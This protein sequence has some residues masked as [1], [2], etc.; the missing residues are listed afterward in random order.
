M[1]NLLVSGNGEWWEAPSLSLDVNRFKEFSGTEADSVD[2]ARPETLRLLEE[3]PTLLMYE[4]GAD[5]PHKRL[6]R[7]GRLRNI[8]RRGRDLRF[9]FEPDSERAYLDRTVVLSFADQLGLEQFERHRT[10]WA[11]KDGN[12]PADLLDTATA[13]RQ[14]RTIGVVAAEYVE[15]KRE[16][17]HREIRELEAELEQ[18]PASLEK[19]LFLLPARILEHPTPELY[20]I[21]GI[22][23]STPE[24]RSA[25]EAVFARDAEQQDLPQDWAFSLGWFLDLYGSPTEAV[26]LNSAVDACAAK[27]IGLG[28]EGVGAA[29]S[30][31]EVAY[32][33]WRSSRS[34]L[35]V[36][37]LRREIAMLIDRLVRR[38]TSDGFWAEDRDGTPV[39]TVRATALATVAL[40]RLGDDRYHE[41]IKQAVLWLIAQV[42]P[43]TGGLPR[44]SGETEADVIATTLTME[45]IRRSDV[46]EQ[47]PHVLT[48]GDA[49][50]VA[51]QTV[52]GGWQAEPWAEN[53]VASMVLEYLARQS[54][55]LPQVD[56][57]LLMARDF[58]RKAEELRLEGGA[59]NRRL[60]AI[61]TVHAVEMFLYG[62]F[63]RR[64]D[65]AL[66]A[67]RE[68]GRET[69][70]PREALR[71]LQDALQR[72]GELTVPQRLPHRDNLSALIGKRDGIIHQAQEISEAELGDGMGHARRFIVRYAK[73]LLN[74]NLLQ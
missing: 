66:S 3:V 4:V 51:G 69:L 50:L 42:L 73:S 18:F 2:I 29:R 22:E 58:F 16:G 26:R 8:A 59:N 23:P 43:G 68:N 27:M 11:I 55:M 54:E 37:R 5:G 9:T 70:G 15:A 34:S 39:A 49:W 28:A 17:T 33:L 61:A 63:E 45:A 53:F 38:Q 65:L 60:A 57:F 36:G 52:L 72:I 40:Q 1:F 31:E 32:A 19:A 71:A 20:P 41:P 62:L 21:I 30:I 64:E 7:H 6:V 44:F 56:G 25:L 12:L 74:L 35:L 48:A 13:Q 47:V 67:F 10:H 24:G 14:Q 46:A